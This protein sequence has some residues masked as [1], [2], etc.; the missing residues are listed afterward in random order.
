MSSALGPSNRDNRLAGDAS[1]V[2]VLPRTP[3]GRSRGVRQLST[4]ARTVLGLRLLRAADTRVALCKG[5]QRGMELL[6][7]E[8]KVD[9]RHAQ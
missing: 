4:R 6:E 7:V 2:G 8:S 1:A 9:C 3:P 5:I